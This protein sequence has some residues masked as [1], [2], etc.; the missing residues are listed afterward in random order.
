MVFLLSNGQ[1]SCF[2]IR[3]VLGCN[4]EPYYPERHAELVLNRVRQMTGQSATAPWATIVASV[5][6]QFITC[7]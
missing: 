2:C 4:S 7:Y 3:K 6:F 1:L 5:A